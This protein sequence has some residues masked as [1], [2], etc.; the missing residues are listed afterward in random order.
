MSPFEDNNKDS[1]NLLYVLVT[2]LAIKI[3]DS[4]HKRKLTAVGCIML[5]KLPTVI[6]F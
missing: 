3:N 6:E 1:R 2:E 4:I 5:L